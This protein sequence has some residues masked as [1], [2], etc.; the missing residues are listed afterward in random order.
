MASQS[1]SSTSNGEVT[2]EEDKHDIQ[3]EI[4]ITEDMWVQGACGNSKLV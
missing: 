1:S 4:T 3:I 2:E